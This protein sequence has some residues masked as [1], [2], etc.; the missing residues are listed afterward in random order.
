MLGWGRFK[1]A[2]GCGVATGLFQILMVFTAK[3]NKE[4]FL[5]LNK[6]SLCDKITDDVVVFTGVNY[7][8]G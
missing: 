1:S 8:D 2:G 7:G 6:Q 3:S 4:Y 5:A